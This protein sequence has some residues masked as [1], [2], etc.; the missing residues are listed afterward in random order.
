MSSSGSPIYAIISKRTQPANITTGC[1]A[2]VLRT[3][4]R[5]A[6]NS[7]DAFI[8][9]GA[10]NAS[11][12][13]YAKLVNASFAQTTVITLPDPGVA[14]ASLVLNSSGVP[15]GSATIVASTTHTQVGAT[16][17]ATTMVAVTTANA[18]D[19]VKLPAAVVGAQFTVA[20]LSASNALQVYASGSDTINGTAGSTGVSQAASAVT[21]YAC[22]QATKWLSK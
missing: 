13:I 2:L 17:I 1:S 16:A 19:A 21:I 9:Q 15:S 11:T 12:S 7:A 3:G 4:T 8:V 10:P 20:N 18:A 5:E 22:F 6:G 14:A